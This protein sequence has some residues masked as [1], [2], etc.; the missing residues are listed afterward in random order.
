MKIATGEEL[1]V[2]LLNLLK[3][4]E[5]ARFYTELTISHSWSP[6]LVYL[7]LER[8]SGILGEIL[9]NEKQ[10]QEIIEL[11]LKAN[12]LHIKRVANPTYLNCLLAVQMNGLA[13]QFISDN[14]K[15]NEL[16]MAAV[17]S[18][19][20]A[21]QFCIDASEEIEKE[22][23]KENSSALRFASKT[24]DNIMLAFEKGCELV[25]LYVS[26]SIENY[27]D[28]YEIALQNNGHSIRFIDYE[29]QTFELAKIAF[30]ERASS[31]FHMKQEL[32]YELNSLPDYEETLMKFMR[33]EQTKSK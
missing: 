28:Y 18:D 15:T 22:A 27:R 13:L 25:M 8:F 26:Q 29:D 11:A 24:H 1:N 6:E 20:R 5:K 32:K 16:Q 21:L 30:Y 17:K 12:G 31:R 33:G 3:D 14:F 9:E 7:T 4:S 10:T 2:F 23:I 19:G